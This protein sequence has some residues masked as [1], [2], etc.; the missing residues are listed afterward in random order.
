MYIC[1]YM[2]IYIYT[3]THIL[4]YVFAGL[5]L[6]AVRFASRRRVL[7]VAAAAEYDIVDYLL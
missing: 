4:I 2:Y 6:A 3:Y 1:M 5:L 7:D